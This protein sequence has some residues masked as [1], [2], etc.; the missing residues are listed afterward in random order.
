MT[1]IEK[2]LMSRSEAADYLGLT[3]HTLAVWKCAK[4]YDL[5]CVKIGGLA[6]YRKEDLDS[7]IERRTTGLADKE[8]EA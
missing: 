3:P 5:P 1:K 2:N 7:F 4:R 8:G 6:K